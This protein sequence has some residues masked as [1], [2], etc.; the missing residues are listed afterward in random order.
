MRVLITGASG[1]IGRNVL[2]RAPRSWEVYAV[3]HRTPGLD[4]FA[5]R[6]GLANVSA[7]QCDLTNPAD[8]F[9]LIRRTGPVDVCLHLAAN[10]D[11]ARSAQQPALDLQMNTLALVVLLERLRAGHFVYVSSGAVYDRL[12]GEVT[13]GTP[14]APRLPYAISKLASEH[15]LRAIAERNGTVGSF[16]NVR[17]FGAFGPFEP[18]RKITTRWVQSVMNGQREFTI[19]GDGENLIDLMYV[20][21]AVD[22]F[23][24]L[25]QAAGF[26]GTVDV[27]SGTP[28]TVNDIVQTLARVLGV[29]TAIR[30]EGH[31][32]E[33]IRFRSVDRTMR[34]R[35]GFIPAIPF[36]EG[37]RRLHRHLLQEARDAGQPA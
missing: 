24:R 8:V 10:G 14:V 7:V 22:A 19:R 13:P 12:E 2:L 9:Q 34:D 35:F 15:Y 21:D 27:A 33:Y 29:D 4:A 30:H 5:A 16:I 26:S 11:P 25:M 6:H 28:V 17:F 36:E 37:M 3:Y 20:D 32:E 18:P 23:L 31:T 1:F